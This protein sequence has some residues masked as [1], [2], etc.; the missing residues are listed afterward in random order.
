MALFGAFRKTTA[1]S[2]LDA[3][4]KSSPR[5]SGGSPASSPVMT[6]VA[7]GFVCLLAVF[8]LGFFFGDREGG[9]LLLTA[10]GD[11]CHI[12]IPKNY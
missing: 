10:L 3:H 2:Q 11:L 12:H 4:R 8:F 6:V 9:I 5:A 7:N 1:T